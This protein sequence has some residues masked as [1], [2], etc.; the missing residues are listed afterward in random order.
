MRGSSWTRAGALAAPLAASLL[1]AGWSHAAAAACQSRSGKALR[2]LVELY[3]AEGCNQCPAADA[4]LSA[5][6]RRQPRIS[7]LAFHVDYW[8]AVGWVDRYAAAAHGQRQQYRLQSLGRQ[9]LVTPQVI[10]GRDAPVDWRGAAMAQLLAESSR[11]VAPATLAMSANAQADGRMRVDMQARLDGD[12]IAG[13]AL[14]W[15]ALYEDGLETAVAAGENA[16][17]MLRH[18]RVVRKLAGPWKL[19][20]PAWNGYAVLEL[21]GDLQARRAGLVLFA[22]SPDDGRGLQSLELSLARC[23]EATVP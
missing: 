14:L 13:P 20:S 22:E 17:R 4:W 9:A 19:E 3:T 2:P 15:L 6:A 16:G 1:L 8:D 23:A 10:V 11:Q 21:P 5:S 18:D 7:W 12:R